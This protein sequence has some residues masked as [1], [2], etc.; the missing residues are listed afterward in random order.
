[1]SFASTAFFE[2]IPI[3]FQMNLSVWVARRPPGYAFIEFDDR[4]DALDAVRDLD[5]EKWLAC[6]A[7]AIRSG[8]WWSRGRGGDDMKCY[9]C[10]EPGHF[11]SRVPLAHWS[12]RTLESPPTARGRYESPYAKAEDSLSPRRGHGSYS[13]S[14]A[15]KASS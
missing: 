12:T 3:F 11:C 15:Y 10:G 2:G 5:G 14:P 9:E 8:K 7:P 4:R 13:R 6:R 1:M